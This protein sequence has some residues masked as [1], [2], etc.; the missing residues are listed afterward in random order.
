MDPRASTCSSAQGDSVDLLHS[1][2]LAVANGGATV[3]RGVT[4]VNLGNGDAVEL[5]DEHERL[6]TKL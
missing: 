5:A 3:L 6:K 2:L 4:P 1:R